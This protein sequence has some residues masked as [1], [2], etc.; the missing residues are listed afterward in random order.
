[1]SACLHAYHPSPLHTRCAEPV[2]P[3]LLTP[4]IS[5]THTYHRHQ[6]TTQDKSCCTVL[7]THS[8]EECEAL[9]TRISI[10]VAGPS[11]RHAN[12]QVHVCK[13]VC[14][15]IIYRFLKKTHRS[16][17]QILIRTL[18]VMHC[19]SSE[20]HRNGAT[21]QS[22][23]RKILHHGNCARSVRWSISQSVSGWLRV[24]Q[25]PACIGNAL[26]I[27]GRVRVR[28]DPTHTQLSISSRKY[29]HTR[30]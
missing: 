18:P 30:P 24:R 28:L 23:L 25:R 8:M 19:R 22:A 13:P 11:G 2:K 12:E 16:I 1:M 21:P 17:T 27:G 3:L 4:L 10:M 5:L 26:A 9:C 14:C 20:V 29:I 15:S 7:T 6:V